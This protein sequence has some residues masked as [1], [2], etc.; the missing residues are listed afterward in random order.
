ML[1]RPIFRNDTGSDTTGIALSIG[2]VSTF[3]YTLYLWLMFSVTA[4]WMSEALAEGSAEAGNSARAKG[5]V[6]SADFLSGLV[7]STYCYRVALLFGM[8]VTVGVVVRLDDRVPRFLTAVAVAVAGCLLVSEWS[9][10][11]PIALLFPLLAVS[12]SR[13][14]VAATLPAAVLT[15]AFM[16]HGFETIPFKRNVD[17][18]EGGLLICLVWTGVFLGPALVGMAEGFIRAK[19]LPTD[20]SQDPEVP[21]DL[22]LDPDTD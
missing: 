11:Q 5:Y 22:D 15:V 2:L 18:T 17:F 16:S 21:L 3:F 6:V 20:A 10:Y 4:W 9:E 1:D 14:A 7:D 12:A 19:M 13:V 8:A